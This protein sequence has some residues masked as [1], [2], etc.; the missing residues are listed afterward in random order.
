VAFICQI[1]ESNSG[2]TGSET[3]AA[4]AVR[5]SSCLEVTRASFEPVQR[6]DLAWNRSR[7][8]TTSRC[9]P[10]PGADRFKNTICCIGS[11]ESILSGTQSDVNSKRSCGLRCEEAKFNLMKTEH[12]GCCGVWCRGTDTRTEMKQTRRRE[13]Q[14]L[15][16]TGT[17]RGHARAEADFVVGGELGRQKAPGHAA[18]VATRARA[19]CH[20][21][22]ERVTGE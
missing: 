10:T 21:E 19:R 11:K 2:L 15:Q 17:R 22:N 4:T 14:T 1:E 12:V 18:A 5:C 7:R 8:R 20:G 3:N 6:A 16:R 9:R 13:G